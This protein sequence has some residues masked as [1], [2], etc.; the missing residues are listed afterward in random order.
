MFHR[1]EAAVG[2]FRAFDTVEAFGEMVSTLNF[3]LPN[4]SFLSLAALIRCLYQITVSYS[5][6]SLKLFYFLI[7]LRKG[8][9]ISVRL[10]PI[11]KYVQVFIEMRY[12]R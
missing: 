7:G 4:R 10:Y 3:S 8:Y 6:L 2:E 12:H 5:F 9:F 11:I 1:D